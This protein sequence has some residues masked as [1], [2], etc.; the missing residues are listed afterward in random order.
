MYLFKLDDFIY[1]FFKIK[2]KLEE[3]ELNI[4]TFT[5]P[6]LWKLNFKNFIDNNSNEVVLFQYPSHYQHNRI[7]QY[8][9]GFFLYFTIFGSFFLIKGLKD[10]KKLRYK[11][12]IFFGFFTAITFFEGVVISSRVKDPKSITLKNGKTL[13]IKTFQDDQLEY[14]MDIKDFRIVNKDIQ[15]LII[16]IDVNMAKNKDFKFFFIEPSPGCVNN[17]DL[18]NTVLVDKRYLTYKL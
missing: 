17:F 7:F 16:L 5:P 11:S 10:L 2:W 8:D 1:K 4:P 12:S 13:C 3:E 15:N 9:Y 6:K 18:F 14:Q